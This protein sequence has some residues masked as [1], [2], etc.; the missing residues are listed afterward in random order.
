[1]PPRS[2]LKPIKLYGQLGPN[3]PKVAILLEE[4]NLPHEAEA[5]AFQDVKKPE[6][7]AIN[8]NGRVPAIYD[9]NTDLTLWESG[10]ILEY[11][12]ER[13]DTD[14]KFSFAPGSN[15][16]FLAKQWLFFQVSGQGPYYGQA[17]WFARHHPE[18][19]QNKRVT[20]VLEGHLKKQREEYGGTEGFNGP[21]LVG[22]K[23]SY[24]DIAFVPW[25]WYAGKF[26]GEEPGQYDVDKFPVV[27]GWLEK[28]MARESLAKVMQK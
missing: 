11:L 2:D 25:Q 23:L 20:D 14:Q 13:Y 8:P 19:F 6:F 4:L 24:A 9:P 12:I 7:L 17:V 18:K 28:L 5:I 26:F 21:W 3:P 16:A 27:K 1:M 22:N 10:A 15:E